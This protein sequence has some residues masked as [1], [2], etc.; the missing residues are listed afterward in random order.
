[1][2]LAATLGAGP[3]PAATP[4]DEV[5]ALA[6]AGAPRLALAVLDRTQPA[7]AADREGWLAAERQR[8]ELLRE[9]G[10]W[11]AL[12]ARVAEH[13]AGLPGDFVRASRTLQAEALLAR[14]DTTAAREL[15]AAL[16][17]QPA[18]AGA[19]EEL[20]AWRR[21]VI[22]GQ[23]DAGLHEDAY[24]ALQRYRQDHGDDPA[25]RDLALRVLLEAGR[26]QAALA[27][28]GSASDPAA[29]AV[30]LL[31][32]LRAGTLPAAEVATAAEKSARAAAGDSDPRVATR[33]WAVAAEA[34]GTAG[35]A[36]RQVAALEA[37]LP[38]VTQQDAMAAFDLAPRTLWQAYRTHGETLGNRAQLLV[39]QDP[40][41]FELAT[42][43]LAQDPQGGR[44]LLSVIM[45]R[46][47]DPGLV[48]AA[49]TAFAA[50]LAGA[51]RGGLLLRRLY[52]DG[53]TDDAV[54]ALPA[55][56]RL[57]LAEQLARD[58]ELRPAAR[59]LAVLETPPAGEADPFAWQLRRA[60]LL[61]L[62]GERDLAGEV[63]L[64]L[65][66][67]QPEACLAG[68][69]ALRDAVA[70]LGRAGAHAAAGAV[71]LELLALD[72]LPA[73]ARREVTV[74]LAE[75]EL[76]GGRP[77]DAA[78][79]FLGAA[80][81][82]EPGAKQEAWR[83]EQQLRGARALAEAG[84]TGDATNLLQALLEGTR[85]RDQR[86]ELEAELRRLRGGG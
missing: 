29:D 57:R 46:G 40:A 53:T 86:T 63:L 55:P 41:W 10:D 36:A 3:L 66:R 39:G 84:L 77:L 1:M 6:T 33:Y 47:S 52:L 8:L 62:G 30:R 22:R 74:S 13:P 15:L 59:L 69:D 49:H 81:L 65:V 37:G 25:F 16:I 58:G 68:L 24:L 71:L 35:D 11:P 42:A 64:R 45:A 51:E 38:P 79:H 67:T 14:G 20:A 2:L 23:L 31:A 9:L 60:R 7:L 48:A 82:A 21:L 72:A 54:A 70:D 56:V 85:K 32:S 19:P 83:R 5:A 17:W 28:L 80:A 61:A 44:A 75:S 4:T 34:A 50:S 18:P 73:A 76:A 43:T 26:P 78:R 12:A 27:L